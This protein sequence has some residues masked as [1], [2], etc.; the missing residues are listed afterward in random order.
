MQHPDE[1]TIHAW[2]DGALSADEVAGLE[3]HVKEC[4]ECAAAVAEARGFIAASSRILTALDDAPR[5]V[6]PAARPR[7]RFDTTM[8][9]IAASLVVVAA[10]TLVVVRNQGGEKRSEAA[11][12]DT[13]SAMRT[14]GPVPVVAVPTEP[15][16]ASVAGSQ[17]ST[18]KAGAVEPGQKSAADNAA[19]APTRDGAAASEPRAGQL[20]SRIGA[21]QGRGAVRTDAGDVAGNN[22]KA[23]GSDMAAPAAPTP[24]VPLRSQL[25]GVVALDRAV[26]SEPLKVIDTTRRIGANVTVYEV[27]GDTVTLTESIGSAFSNVVVTGAAAA[28]AQGAGRVETQSK[29][30]ETAARRP[31][32]VTRRVSAP[33]A[34]SA[35][36][37]PPPAEGRALREAMETSHT[38]TWLDLPTGKTFTLTGKMSEAR[39]QQIRL[40]IERERA[41]APTKQNP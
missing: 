9:R 36:V 7:R 27:A 28:A 40:R 10:G 17:S 2:L 35:A 34:P 29:R 18:A 31:D 19:A 8:L 12:L 1:G 14:V 6:I 37:V 16:S 39:L 3:A 33:S 25:T 11:S 24:P 5:G 22:E 38:I 32:S 26:A 4:P 20:G 15:P 30:T 41:T 21:A 13:A 23:A